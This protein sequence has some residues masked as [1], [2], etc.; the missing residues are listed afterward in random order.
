MTLPFLSLLSLLLLS[1]AAAAQPLLRIS[2]ENTSEHFQTAVVAAFAERVRAGAEG[3]LQVAFYPNAALF[4]DQDVVVA[5]REGKVE[6]AVPGTWQLGRF[7]P[8]V[9]V[10]LLP[11]FY[12]QSR[13][14]QWRLQD[15]TPV[16]EHINADIEWGTRS[17]VL[18]RWIDLGHTHL[19]S[20]THPLLRHEDLA[21]L[22]IR[23]AGGLANDAR[24]RGLGALP[25]LVPWPDVPRAI[26]AGDMDGLLTSHATVASA[27]LWE[28]GVSYA[29]EDRQYFAR[30]VPLVAGRFWRRLPDE[31]KLLLSE[32]W[33]A[34]VEEAR[35]KA[36]GA[37]LQAR[38][39]LA[40]QGIA[41]ATP[42]DTALTRWR[43]RLLAQQ[44]AL[45]T[46]LGIDP[47]LVEQAQQ[48]LDGHDEDTP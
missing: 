44:P 29:F 22:R 37:Q 28:L 14:V 7:A 30:Y 23:I 41:I 39:E 42:S 15:S 2:T 6:M 20:L 11:L 27:Q 36:H 43:Q 12:G 3:R 25:T 16:G 35:R 33:E 19:Y 8:D 9:G 40:Q 26:A 46:E 34:G 38:G 48:A 10:Y 47:T 5:L 24:L 21:G 4:R 31:L 17:H 1:L 32:S 13:E 45:I 18:G